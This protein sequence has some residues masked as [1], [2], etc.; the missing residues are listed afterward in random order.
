MTGLALAFRWAWCESWPAT[1]RGVTWGQ[2]RLFTCC[3]FAV[4]V[5]TRSV[6]LP[7]LLP[8]RAIVRIE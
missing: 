3:L 8:S 7:A 1:T 2:A 5:K 4:L 6:K